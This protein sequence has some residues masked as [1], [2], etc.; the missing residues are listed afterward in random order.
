[1]CRE[2]RLADPELLA[3]CDKIVKAQR[4]EINQMEAIAARLRVA[5]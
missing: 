1:M 2:A 4:A 5:T 3:L